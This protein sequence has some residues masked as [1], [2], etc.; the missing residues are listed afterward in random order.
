[1]ERQLKSGARVVSHNTP[2]APWVPAKVE[3]IED[4]GDGHSHKLYLYRR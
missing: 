4:D 2:F 3:T 1:L